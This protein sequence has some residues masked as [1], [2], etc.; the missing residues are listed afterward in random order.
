MTHLATLLP[1]GN[2]G[3]GGQP[4]GSFCRPLCPDLP[5]VA[6]A[7]KPLPFLSL[8]LSSLARTILFIIKIRHE[9]QTSP[10]TETWNGPCQN[11]QYH[12]RKCNSFLPA[13]QITLYPCHHLPFW[14]FVSWLGFLTLSHGICSLP[15][16]LDVQSPNH[17]TA[18]E[19][20]F[21][22]FCF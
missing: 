14:G 4:R 21:F 22:C 1:A 11:V 20:S 6:A 12:T 5:C 10:Y 15:P 9:E 13:K 17:W 2:T 16:A 8:S 7:S 18:R 3:Q 19:V